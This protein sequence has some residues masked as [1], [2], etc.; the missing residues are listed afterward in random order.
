[1]EVNMEQW[2]EVFKGMIPRGKYQVLLENGEENGLLVRLESKNNSVYINFGAV[3]AFRMLDEGIVLD[4][5]FE[6]SQIQK[7][8]REDFANVI[9]KLENGEFGKF[10][11]TI[12]GD[13]CEYLGLKHFVI[14]TMNYIIEIIT[15]WEP[16]INMKK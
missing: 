13:L 8:K 9:Y 4:N 16:Q 7:Y 10:V 14:I 11:K 1:M 3:S 15:R 6:E 12:G 5:L 2:E